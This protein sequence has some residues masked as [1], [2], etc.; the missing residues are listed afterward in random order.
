MKLISKLALLL[1]ILGVSGADEKKKEKGEVILDHS[2]EFSGAGEGNAGFYHLKAVRHKESKSIEIVELGIL[3]FRGRD[4]ELGSTVTLDDGEIPVV[5][6]GTAH[7]KVNR[8][9]CMRGALEI[10][11]DKINIECE[12]LYSWLAK[13]QIDPPKKFSKEGWKIPKGTLVFQSAL[14][15]SAPLL[16]PEAGEL[17]DMVLAE[18]PDDLD[19]PALISFREKGRLVRSEPEE[20][21]DYSIQLFNSKA[22][23]PIFSAKFSKS[24][25]LIAI[26]QVGQFK[27]KKVK[28]MK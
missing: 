16:L 15:I 20:S 13:E 24:D 2:Y 1:A 27:L 28:S 7:T 5:K 19:A 17:K 3:S 25:D 4:V 26:E 22:T 23:I 18:F 14:V 6:S 10:N 8:N 11:G 21:G 12:G 9:Q